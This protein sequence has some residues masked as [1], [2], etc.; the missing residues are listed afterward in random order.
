MTRQPLQGFSM[1][2]LLC[3]LLSMLLAAGCITDKVTTDGPGPMPPKPKPAP[4][5]PPG[6]KATTLALMMGPKPLDTNGNGYP[7]QIQLEAFLF[8]EPHPTPVIE[9]GG[10]VFRLF[11]G[12]EAANPAAS[13]LI[14]WRI[15]GEDL[16]KSA[17]V[18]SLVGPCWRI[19]LMLPLELEY[20]V[21]VTCDLVAEFEPVDG[22]PAIRASGVRTIQFQPWG[23]RSESSTASVSP[24]GGP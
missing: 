6:A 23:P 13:P 17:A 2:Q 10:F 18:S 1:V 21:P 5:P 19:Q 12:R 22:R 24:I 20:R 16:A 8:C 4:T 14:S 3:A 9:A 15:E 7:D 11:A